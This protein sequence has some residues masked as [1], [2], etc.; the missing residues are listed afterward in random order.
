[1][2]TQTYSFQAETRKLLDLMIHSLYS[3]K[4]IFLRE[5][6]SNASDALDRLRF[7]ALTHENLKV[8]T[9]ELEIRL[10]ADAKA[11]TLTIHDNGIGMT[12][13]EVIDHIG[14][15]ARS[16]TKELIEQLGESDNETKSSLIGQFGVGFYSSFMVA[17]RVTLITRKAGETD[18]TLWESTGDGQFQISDTTRDRQGTSIT[19]HLKDVDRENKIDDFTQFWTVSQIVKRYSDFVR[20]PIKMKYESRQPVLDDDGKPK[21]DEYEVHIED[22]V[23]NSM[24]PLWMR[25]ASEVTEEEYAEFYRQLSHDWE[26]PLKTLHFSVEGR[27]E[28]RSILFLPQKAPRDLYMHV[29]ERG[30]RLYTRNVLI[31]EHSGDLLPS[32]LRFV[33][34]VVDSAD[35]SLNVSREMIQQD[36]H[37]TQIRKFLTKK[38]LD[39]CQD[40]FD[41][42]RETYLKFWQELGRTL[43]EGAINDYD[44][45]D[46][47]IPL[48]LFD[49]SHSDEKTT[50][51]QYLER[52]KEEQKDIYYLT[53]NSREE[54][55]HS[56]HLEAF[57]EK[58]YEV[59]FLSD[60]ID[61]L[62]LQSL[63]E[64]EDCSFTAIDKGEIELGS[65]T[66][67]EEKKKDIEKKKES[68]ASLLEFLQKKLENK[69][70]EVRLSHRLTSSPVCLVGD[71][72]T[73]NPQLERLLNRDKADLPKRKRTLEVN[74]NHPLIL[75]MQSLFSSDPD[76]S[77]LDGYADLLLGYATLAE[78]EKLEQ[79]VRFNSLLIEIMERELEE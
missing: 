49:S 69:V 70:K 50:L 39:T 19:L 2:S 37:V 76:S 30:L 56:P 25:P 48:L 58:G 53:G 12:R 43:K 1:M 78:G 32:Y 3:N 28:Y 68:F 54:I 46:K 13:Q 51:K 47:L 66:E 40:M 23:L 14:T 42:E 21:D 6:I 9:D 72:N 11:R 31:K 20:Y 29:A 41:N 52:K 26:K 60:P 38:V 64:Y 74:P 34:G 63:Y 44:H 67:K 79:P 35:I 77:R 62:V 18:A 61:E 57:Q 16:G 22:R 5:L 59:L 8:D 36:R 73:L 55:Q 65:E 7:F 71:E 75:K 27:L 10:E 24:K 45:R 17:D 15:I 33:Q 4:E